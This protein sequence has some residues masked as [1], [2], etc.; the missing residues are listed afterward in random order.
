MN[1]RSVGLW[2]IICTFVPF[3]QIALPILWILSI[4][5]AFQE[6][7]KSAKITSL[8]GF[9]PFI[10]LIMAFVTFVIL[11]ASSN[12]EKRIYKSSYNTANNPYL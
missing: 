3:F 1:K 2:G 9:V 5:V 12:E 7:I 6:D 8:L 4:I 11:L 10:G